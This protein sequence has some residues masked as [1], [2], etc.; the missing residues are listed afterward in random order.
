VSREQPGDRHA[1]GSA[2]AETERP[3]SELKP[4]CIDT[5]I[6]LS[7]RSTILPENDEV[8]ATGAVEVAERSTLLPGMMNLGSKP[9]SV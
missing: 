3:H 9:H 8:A 7:C 1:K 5:E 4:N 6:G 2:C